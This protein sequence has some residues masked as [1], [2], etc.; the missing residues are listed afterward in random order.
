[1]GESHEIINTSIVSCYVVIIFCCLL[2]FVFVID[3]LMP[4]PMFR[5]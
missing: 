2:V 5:S 1:M 4:L 3:S